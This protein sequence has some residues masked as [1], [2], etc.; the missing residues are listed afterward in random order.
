MVER[1]AMLENLFNELN[2]QHFQGEL[3]LPRLSWNGR[4][5]S[6]AGR[7]C[8]GHRNAW[9]EKPAEI[10]IA[11]YLRD[12]P[13]GYDHIRDTMLHEMVH[14]I[15]WHRGRPYGHTK[16]FNRILKRVGAKRW[17]TVPKVRPVKHWY[18]CDGCLKY[19]PARRE[20]RASACAACCQKHNGGKFHARFLLKPSSPPPQE[21]TV[22][23]IVT[24]V[25]SPPPPPPKDLGLSSSEIVRRLE[26]IKNLILRAR[27]VPTTIQK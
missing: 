13:D 15:L 24:P 27:G 23:P 22:V 1:T 20:I 16:E 9:M 21:Q 4:L 11:Q 10:E 2:V 14:Y 12:L 3:P 19:I 17:N 18:R 26:E 7:F 6:S 25:A 5:S 8:P